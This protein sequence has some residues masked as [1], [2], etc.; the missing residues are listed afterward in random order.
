[1]LRAR[2]LTLSLAALT[3]AGLTLGTLPAAAYAD[4]PGTVTANETLLT[5][6]FTEFEVTPTELDAADGL[7]TYR[8]RIVYVDA[9]GV[10]HPLAGATIYTPAHILPVLSVVT[11]A[12]G[13]FA[14]S[15]Y[16]H[17]S[18]WFR[19]RY[20]RPADAPYASAG[21]P[22]VSVYVTGT[23][24][25]PTRMTFEMTPTGKV[26][27]QDPVTMSGRLEWQR[28]TG[29]WLPLPSQYVTVRCGNGGDSIAAFRT[30]LDGAFG[31]S[32]PIKARCATYRAQFYNTGTGALRTAY[33][34][35]PAIPDVYV[36]TRYADVRWPATV[37]RGGS[38][39]V[40]GRVLGNE[41][42]GSSRVASTSVILEYS[43][44]GRTWKKVDDAELDGDSAFRLSAPAPGPGRWRIRAGEMPYYYVSPGESL[45]PHVPMRERTRFTEVNAS[46]EPVRKGGTITFKARLQRTTAT[47][48][49]AL[50]WKKVT[51][52]FR[53][54]G[55]TTWRNM[56]TATTGKL[57]YVTKTFTAAKDGTWRV[58]YGGETAYLAVTGSGD[59]VDVR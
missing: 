38:M 46:P 41:F 45:S 53:A 19:V 42:D 4:D 34:H 59:Y 32:L 8:G 49:T 24:N 44:D 48:W 31:G 11:D 14:G 5:T 20:L 40:P 16:L 47:G 37:T 29:E 25:V 56:A 51:V 18:N 36:R 50:P 54:H 3:A 33:A 43:T 21:S 22:A 12:D 10:E 23:Q 39:S 26:F 2:P 55:T 15:Y 7:V 6:K 28:N 13:R 9:E 52:Q 27:A 35:P 30:K 17:G 57:G 58:V 1:M